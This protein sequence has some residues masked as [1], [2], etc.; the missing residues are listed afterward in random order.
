VQG[1][2]ILYALLLLAFPCTFLVA[3]WRGYH[4]LSTTVKLAG[5]LLRRPFA[6]SHWAQALYH[7]EE[8]AI[9][10]CHTHPRVVG[11]G[12]LIS[13]LTWVGVLGEFWLLTHMLGLSLTPL[14][15]LTSLVA[16]R[17]AILLPVPAGL[18]TLEAG[19]VLAM[20]IVGADPS[21]GIA[22]AVVIRARDLVLGLVGLALG[23]IHLWQ[24]TGMLKMAGI[25]QPQPSQSAASILSTS[26]AGA[27]VSDASQ[28]T[29]QP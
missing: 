10:L 18:G 15:A 17:I 3:L 25:M 21:A 8:Q 11:I 20:Q 28:S 6:H 16:A 4:P 22:I 13:I 23:G 19:Q 29:S 12:F 7:S 9:W 2:L 26:D 5:R 27:P 14:Q 24:S 1:Q